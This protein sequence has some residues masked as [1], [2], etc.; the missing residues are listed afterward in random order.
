MRFAQNATLG[1]E[2]K[3]R[4]DEDFDSEVDYGSVLIS[5]AH[6]TS[7]ATALESKRRLVPNRL[8]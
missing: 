3:R 2:G 5:G 4:F 1:E 7:L 8:L 6:A